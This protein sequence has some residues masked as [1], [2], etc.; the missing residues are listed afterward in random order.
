[1]PRI[2]VR[3]LTERDGVHYFRRAVPKH[4]SGK[5][6]PSRLKWSLKT[7]SQSEALRLL[8]EAVRRSDAIIAAAEGAAPPLSSDALGYFRRVWYEQ[9]LAALPGDAD[10]RL[11]SLRQ[12]LLDIALQ[13]L[14]E[15]RPEPLV[16]G[17]G[18][19]SGRIEAS[20]SQRP[21]EDGEYLQ[22]KM[23][24]EIELGV[25]RTPFFRLLGEPLQ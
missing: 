21:V 3:Y 14:V 25:D 1:M 10:L 13:H 2:V 12:P 22:W 15:N 6:A 8:P 20:L 4:L 19:I 24:Q 23:A 17:W 16:G 5:L 9:R 7:K 18:E 11:V